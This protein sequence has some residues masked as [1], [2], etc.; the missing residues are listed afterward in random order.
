MEIRCLT[1][2]KTKIGNYIFKSYLLADF[3]ISL[4]RCLI[5][6]MTMI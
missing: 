3:N 4:T 5:F 2:L 6:I 1:K